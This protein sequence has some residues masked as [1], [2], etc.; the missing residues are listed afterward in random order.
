MNILLVDDNPIFRRTYRVDPWYLASK[1]HRVTV[2]C[3]NPFQIRGSLMKREDVKFVYTV[4]WRAV[5][6]GS[7][8]LN[9]AAQIAATTVKVWALLR[10]E[11]Y[12]LVRAVGLLSAYSTLT[13]RWRKTVP[14]VSSVMDF[15][16]E[17]YGQF[18]LS[19]A[20]IMAR[21]LE[22]MERKVMMESDVLFVDSPTMRR[23][24]SYWGLEERKCAVLPNAYDD[25]L[26]RPEISPLPIKAEYG[27]D[28]STKIVLYAGDISWMDGLDILIEAAPKILKEIDVKFLILGSGPEIY[29]NQLRRMIKEK[30]LERHVIFTGWIPYASVPGFIAA[31]DICVAPYRITLTSNSNAAGKLVEYVAMA[32]PVVATRADGSLKLFGDMLNYVPQ[33]NPQAL[34]EAVIKTLRQGPL[35]KETVEKMKAI[36]KKFTFRNIWENEEKIMR[37][38]I[39]H[40]VDDFRIFDIFGKDFA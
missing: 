12:D 7:D 24:W 22:R 37:A 9:K 36:S 10:Y 32:K 17:M 38:L 13:A 18:M 4:P 14:V 11:K 3:P 19:C 33:E 2:V 31:A 21:L 39:N 5:K 1:G 23:Y 25:D 15:Y 40:E 16:S 30:N 27:I 34:V 6:K 8:L 29:I 26:F 35:D 28:D 20:P